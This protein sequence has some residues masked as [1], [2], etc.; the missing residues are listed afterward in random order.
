MSLLP[1]VSPVQHDWPTSQQ[2]AKL[3]GEHAEAGAPERVVERQPHR[4]AFEELGPHSV[5]FL[6]AVEP[7]AQRNR[8]PWCRKALSSGAPILNSQQYFDYFMTG[9]PG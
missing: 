3:I 5:L 6:D 9:R 4:P 2:R 1:V 7:D 8:L